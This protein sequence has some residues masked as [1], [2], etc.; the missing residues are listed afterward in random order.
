LGK[1]RDDR[2]NPGPVTRSIGKERSWG[3]IAVAVAVASVLGAFLIVLA[4][5]LGGETADGALEGVEEFEVEQGHTQGTVSYEQSP[6]A[7]GEHNPAWQNSG[8]YEEPVRNE[9]AVHTMEHGAVWISYSPDLPEEQVDT[10]RELVDGQECMLASPYEGLDAP[11]V[12]SAWGRQLRLDSADDPNLE[13]FVEAFLRGPQ[14]PEPG[15]ACAG[16]VGD[17]RS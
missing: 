7:G 1:Q 8:F 11:V 15:A 3:T 2:E 17:P 5:D 16:G 10:L 12:A 9:T 13:Q 6:P 14:T 4:I